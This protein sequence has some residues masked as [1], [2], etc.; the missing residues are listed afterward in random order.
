MG[1]LTRANVSQGEGEHVGSLLIEFDKAGKFELKNNGRGTMTLSL[2][3]EAMETH[4][5]LPS[6]GCPVTPF[7]PTSVIVDLP[8]ETWSARPAP[9]GASPPPTVKTATGGKVGALDLAI[10]LENKGHTV[11]RTGAGFLINGIAKTFDQAL[12]AANAHRQEA[13]LPALDADKAW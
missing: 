11:Q 5:A 2:S 3:A 6:E 4:H 12:R 13:N 7:T 10:Y 9:E 8:L 1:G